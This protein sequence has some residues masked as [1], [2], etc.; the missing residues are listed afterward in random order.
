LDK[1]HRHLG[2]EIPPEL[3]LGNST[4]SPVTRDGLA[5][6]RSSTSHSLVTSSRRPSTA[7]ADHNA[8]ESQDSGKKRR[9]L[10]SSSLQRPLLDHST[11]NASGNKGT[12]LVKRKRSLWMKHA[13][14]ADKDKDCDDLGQGLRDHTGKKDVANLGLERHVSQR[15]R[16]LNVKRA[17]KM[18][19]VFGSE[20][21]PN[22]FVFN[23]KE[24][25]EED[26][27]EVV[28]AN[29]QSIA[30][31]LALSSVDPLSP[32]PSRLRVDSIMSID[33]SISMEGMEE[34]G[35]L[36]SE[37]FSG[38]ARSTSLAQPAS[39]HSHISRSKSVDTSAVFRER[40]L[41]AAKLSRFFGVEYQDISSALVTTEAPSLDKPSNPPPSAECNSAVD[42]K[43]SAPARFWGLSEGR[44][45]DAEVADVI[46]KLRGLKA[47]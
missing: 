28:E 25:E 27:S 44:T 33:P 8:T 26:S 23:K 18:A 17:R 29:R 34:L 21:P 31:L 30:T 22:L 42:V 12:V 43:V 24:D 13:R 40:R 10:D 46:G 38:L 9:S 41:R 6:R 15:Q 7:G 5:T 37:P 39:S 36:P 14:H 3:V 16:A 1:L 2:E 35:P 47:G 19:Q 20:P 45:K 4:N 32:L 11:M